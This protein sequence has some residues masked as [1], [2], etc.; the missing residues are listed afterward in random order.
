MGQRLEIIANL[1]DIELLE[2][3][4]GKTLLVIEKN[5][6]NDPNDYNFSDRPK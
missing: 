4:L 6:V 1:L 2:L 3:I 5:K